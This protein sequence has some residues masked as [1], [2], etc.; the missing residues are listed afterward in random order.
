MNPQHTP[1]I[2]KEQGREPQ[3]HHLPRS[4]VAVT[5]QGVK[6]RKNVL[7]I[8]VDDLRPEIAGFGKTKLRT[9]HLDALCAR[10]MQF[11]STYCQYPQCMPS[12]ASVFSGVR[13]NADWRDHKHQFCPNGEPSLPGLLRE[14]GYETIS[15]GKTYHYNDDD[16]D[17]WSRRFTDTF[18]EQE[19]ACHGYCSG[20]QLPENLTLVRSFGLQFDGSR[21]GGVDG[22]RPGLAQL[23]PLCESADAPDDAYPDGIV[24]RRAIELLSESSAAQRPFFMAVGFYRPHLPWAVPKR[25]W[26]LYDRAAVDL[27]DNPFLPDNAV[28]ASDLCDFRHYGDEEVARTYS[29]IGRYDFEDF[30]VLSEEKQRECVHGYWAAVS[31]VDAQIGRVLAELHRTG[32]ADNTIV[33]VWGDN[34]WH[35]G[36]HALWSK[37]TSFEESTRVPLVV[38]APGDAAGGRSSA[39]VELVDLYPTVCDLL[40]LPLPDH[41]EGTSLVPLLDR[42]DRQ[43]KTAVLS[44]IRD[45]E[46]IRTQRYR[47][48]RYASGG[49]EL[50]DLEPDPAENVNVAG[51]SAYS[52]ILEGLDELLSGGWQV[53]TP[54]QP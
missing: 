43:W 14:K 8:S 53:L 22:D 40:D 11:D 5:L 27:A 31:F 39:L 45:A 2:G 49:A 18:Y 23:P 4:P 34:G 7:F 36:E 1:D 24:A 47:Y 3:A 54:E 52:D 10:G 44:R 42:P 29:D 30:P 37:V 38:R 21:R 25:Y 41:V 20:Y 15:I 51:V 16:A 17:S 6:E 19:Y 46:T 33:I 26:D 13:P 9:P 35:L 32:L 48:T 50:F 28:A 12:R